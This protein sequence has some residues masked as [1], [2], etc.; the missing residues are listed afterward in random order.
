MFRLPY[1][2]SRP[3]FDP[4]EAIEPIAKVAKG[5][6]SDDLAF[7]QPGDGCARSRSSWW[8]SRAC[9]LTLALSGACSVAA[10]EIKPSKLRS[11]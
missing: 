4:P 5:R 11:E 8:A 7:R 9:Q 10:R 1:Y 2:V 3:L 6:I